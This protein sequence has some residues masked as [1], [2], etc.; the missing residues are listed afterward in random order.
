MKHVIILLALLLGA[1]GMFQSPAAQTALDIIAPIAKREL[2]ELIKRRHNV[3]P[4]ESTAGCF[5]VEEQFAP[6]DGFDYM[7]CRAKPV[8]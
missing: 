3:E 6:D 8:E 2:T 5:E 1:C 4:D 7:I